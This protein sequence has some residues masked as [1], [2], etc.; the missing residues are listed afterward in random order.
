MVA[1]N[2]R[3]PEIYNTDKPETERKLPTTFALASLSESKSTRKTNN[4]LLT[5]DHIKNLQ[6]DLDKLAE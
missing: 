2:Y 4:T 3:T 6:Q 5:N 1:N